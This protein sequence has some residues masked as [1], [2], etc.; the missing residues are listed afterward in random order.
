[1]SRHLFT[2]ESVSEGHPDKIADQISDAVLDAILAKDPKARVA[3]ETY[4]KTGMVLV[5]G[6]IST[7][8]WV[9]VED[10]ARETVKDIGYR[11][12]DMGFDG[13]SC[14]VLNAIGKQSGDINQGVDRAHPEEQG[15][16][17]QG[18]MFGYA[19][20]ETSVLMPAPITYA[21][22]VMQ[23]QSEVRNNGT[24]D[25]LRPDAKSQL[26]FVYENGKPVAIDT[27][28]LST[29]HREDITQ[30]T[31]REAVMEEII[32]PVLP[33]QWI[34]KDTQFHINP[35]GR[36]VVGGPMG[37]CGLTG[38]KIIVDTYGGMARH[39]GGAFSGKDPSKVDRSAAY[40]ARYV[41]KNL[42]A[43]GLAERCELQI[44]Y[45]I[46]VAEPTSISIDT[47]GTSKHSEEQLIALV[48]RHFDLRP[49]GLIKMLDLERP[50]YKQTAAYGHFGRDNLPWEQTDKAADL[51]AD[52]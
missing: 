8:A 16:G 11:H 32:K 12:S 34:S 13:A 17:D 48:R 19:S 10:L 41:A 39:G 45:A 51:Q 49:Y 46:G 26:T 5:G 38:R 40:A 28:V 7:N 37:D 35:T 24:L 52:I 50:I 25:W 27:V 4:V 6:E 23:R 9:D 47:F 44:S 43:A 42:V 22:R 15:A 18:L 3:C 21:H 14:A 33:E 1:M 30:E 31:L 29:Q 20:N 2:S 36:F